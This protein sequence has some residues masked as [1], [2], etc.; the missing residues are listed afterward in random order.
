MG[1]SS[2]FQICIIHFIYYL[3]KTVSIAAKVTSLFFITSIFLAKNST[4]ITLSP[5]S[6]GHTLLYCTYIFFDNFLAFN[7]TKSK[8]GEVKATWL[9]YPL[10]TSTTTSQTIGFLISEVSKVL[11]EFQFDHQSSLLGYLLYY[12]IQNIFH[13]HRCLRLHKLYSH[14][15][16]SKICKSLSQ[17]ISQP[18]GV[19]GSVLSHLF[20]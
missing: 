16:A 9:F 10:T 13:P 14:Y 11:S 15:L 3:K 18:N 12:I 19:G 4:W 8:M 2:T 17:T 7:L 6:L 20:F 5:D 1:P